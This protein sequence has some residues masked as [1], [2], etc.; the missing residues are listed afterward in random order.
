MAHSTSLKVHQVCSVA[1]PQET[2]PI[3]LPLTFYDVLWIR[4]PPVERLFF[5]EF[6]NQTTTTTTTTSFFD[7][8][9]PNL[10]QSLSLTLQHFLPLVG[11]ITWPNDS[12][13]PIIK[14]V[15]GDAVPFTIAESNADFNH[16]CS[17][18]CDVVER[19]P[20]I[21]RLKISH[22]QASVLALQVTVFPSFGFCIG[23]TT[24]HAALDGKSS[25]LFL[26][27][28]AHLC[29]NLGGSSLPENLTPFFDRSVIR[30][31]SGINDAYVNGWLTYGGE[32]NN[33][34]LKVWESINTA[35]TDA[36]KGLF[37]LTPS[38]IQKLKQYAL[39]KL[40]MKVKLSSFSVTCAYLL[41]CVVKVDQPKSNRVAF[42]FSVDCRS[43]LDPPIV[44]TYI[45]NCVIP[46]AVVVE[47]EEVLGN[48]GFISALKGIIDELNRVENDGVLHD[49]KNWMQKIQSVSG[50]RLFSTAGSPRFEVYSI[51]FGFGR[52]KKVDV[53]SIDKTGAFSLSESKN[54]NGGIEIGLAL[55]KGQM[56]A[57]AALF[58]Q[59]LESL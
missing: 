16:L 7:S 57:F 41:G 25:T 34:S 51:D 27:S 15:P 23:I 14:Y 3:S 36:V 31:P 46:H 12:L 59:G 28:W 26:K 8:I 21:P 50:D 17:N 24:H 48:D 55:N 13:N 30:D 1:P 52:P 33:R 35:Q 56:E 5:Y 40:K 11:N 44:P 58:S 32:T 47:T 38:H 43:R 39:S 45:G 9:L 42:I 37:E 49:A 4:L 2:T 29:S 22:D 20:L 6:H 19:H 10:K 53:A 54:N 18:F